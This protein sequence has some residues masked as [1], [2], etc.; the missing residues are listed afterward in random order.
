MAEPSTSLATYRR[1][2][3]VDKMRK[4]RLLFIMF[5]WVNERWIV[6]AFRG[7]TFSITARKSDP[8]V[9]F[10]TARPS[11][12][13]TGA[14]SIP[15]ISDMGNNNLRTSNIMFSLLSSATNCKDRWGRVGPIINQIPLN[16]LPLWRI[17]R[18]Y[19][20][21]DRKVHLAVN[22]VS[23]T[24]ETDTLSSWAWVCTIF[25]GFNLEMSG[26]LIE[27]EKFRRWRKHEYKSQLVY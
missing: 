26:S 5:T 4:R 24:A 22:V 7:E 11:W 9:W 15:L 19:R 17:P 13:C 25:P 20:R 21:K 12:H 8:T 18:E 14:N 6:A 16:C 10:Y 27:I 1:V 2:A 3:A 23:C